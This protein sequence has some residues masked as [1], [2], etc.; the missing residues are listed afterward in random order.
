M[1]HTVKD[2]RTAVRAFFEDDF[3]PAFAARFSLGDVVLNIGAGAHAYREAF[4]CQVITADIKGGCDRTF[5]AERIP[6][7]EGFLDGILMMGVF[8]R[9]DDPMQAMREMRRV[10]K[11]GG[12]LLFV[13]LDLGT[14]WRKPTDRWR[15]TP[16]GAAHVVRDFVTLQSVNV[17]G[18]AHFFVLQKPSVTVPRD[19]DA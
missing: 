16:G 15:L 10:L 1:A 13:A 7:T 19:T 17:E 12:Y 6:Y 11:P 9:L 14:V 8:E 4:T 5:P 18:C 2:V 3:L